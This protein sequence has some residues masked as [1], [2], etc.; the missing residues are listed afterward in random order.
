M[1]VS[2]SNSYWFTLRTDKISKD[3]KAPIAMFLSINNVRLRYATSL[4]INPVYWSIEAKEA[5]YIKPDEVKRIFKKSNLNSNSEELLTAKEIKDFKD[6]L[7]AIRSRV[8]Q[9]IEWHET[10]KIPYSSKI[11]IDKLS[12]IKQALLIKSR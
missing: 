8:S 2:K 11:V 4:K 6:E 7:S 1:E 10:N 9:L 3:G 12:R 5:I